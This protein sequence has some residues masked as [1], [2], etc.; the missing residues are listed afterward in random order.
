MYKVSTENVIDSRAIVRFH[1]KFIKECTNS[2]HPDPTTP[3][4][5]FIM[6]HEERNT[7]K[8]STCCLSLDF[9]FEDS[10][11]SWYEILIEFPEALNQKR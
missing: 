2:E 1:I 4:L 9:L 6:I 10:R 5:S 7:F 8:H 11:H 3:G